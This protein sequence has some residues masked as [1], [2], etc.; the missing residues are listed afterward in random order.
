VGVGLGGVQNSDSSE[1]VGVPPGPATPPESTDATPS[2]SAGAQSPRSRLAKSRG[3]SKGSRATKA[4]GTT[5]CRLCE[6][7]LPKSDLSYHLVHCTAAH[8]CHDRL[9]KLDRAMQT[10][11]LRISRRKAR[12]QSIFEAMKKALAPLDVVLEFLNQASSG[13]NASADGGATALGDA[14]GSGGK[15]REEDE[16]D[17]LQ[18]TYHLMGLTRAAEEKFA[19]LSDPSIAELAA[20]ASRLA[21]NKTSAYWDLLSLQNPCAPPAT[22]KPPKAS[23]SIKEYALVEPIGTGGFGTVWL[24]RR[25]RTGDL[26]AIKVVSQADTRKRNMSSAVLLEK[27]ILELADHACVVKLLFSFSTPNNLYMV[28]EYQAGGDCFTLLQSYGFL[29]EKLVRWFCAEALLGLQ[30]LHDNAIIH[31]D[32]KP[33]NMLITKDGHIKLA[34]FG[35]SSA[36][37][38]EVLFT[39]S[40]EEAAAT[41]GDVASEVH[42]Q[43]LKLRTGAVGTPDFLAPE[44]LKR[45]EFSYEVDFWALAVVAYQLVVGETPFEAEDAQSVYKRILEQ[46]YN[47]F[48]P[49]IAQVIDLPECGDLLT[50]LLVAEPSQRLG[51]GAPGEGCNTILE[52]A[53][54]APIDPLS[55]DKGP[56]WSRKS[57]FKPTLKHET[58]TA[59]FD[60]NA[61]ARAQAERMRSQLE[62]DGDEPAGT[63][64]RAGAEAA[65]APAGAAAE[66][67]GGGAAEKLD[68]SDEESESSFKSGFKTV[69][70]MMLARSQLHEE[71]GAG[72]E[73]GDEEE[74]EE[75]DE[76]YEEGEVCQVVEAVK[77]EAAKEEAKDSPS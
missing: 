5:I 74:G 47:G 33:S 11:A 75:E 71:R 19:Q 15:K 29:E 12:M 35:L 72:G 40:D 53:Y 34:D 10:F 7:Q 8:S 49:P 50:R 55:V 2:G 6:K 22:H 41:S 18:S 58:D 60:M 77:E 43:P 52:H 59:Y 31:R 36:D 4:K 61:L 17:P 64:E 37:K 30:Y 9:K 13:P 73:A 24:A 16:I 39:T 21:A 51:A 46:A 65:A 28:M 45:H 27:T 56:L 32:V 54:F 38:R 67:G 76:E 14:A 44:L 26:S 69:N 62:G 1:S 20:Q 57:P 70:A 48:E 23:A 68:D 25:R 66:A 3:T 42:I 63:A